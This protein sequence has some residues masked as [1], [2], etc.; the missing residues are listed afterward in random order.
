MWLL[1]AFSGPVLWATSTHLDKY[2]VERYFKGAG[3]AVLMVFTAIV[4]VLALPLIWWW[5]PDVLALP[6]L[7]ITVMTVSGL[8][9]MWAMTVYLQALDGEEASVI[10]PFF[11]LSAVWTLALAYL[12]LHET[13]T[14]SQLAGTSLVFAGG[15][16]L[17]GAGFRNGS[18]IKGT[19]VLRM[20]ACTLILAL[21]GVIFK[22]FAIRDDD[23]WGT[24]FWMF[25]GEALFG[26]AVLLRTT[27][28]RTFLDLLRRS[29]GP[30]VAINAANEL[31][32]LGGGLGVRYAFTLAPIALV[33][34]ITGTTTLFVFLIGI[35]LTRFFPGLGRES[36]DRRD[37]MRKGFAALLVGAGVT[38]MQFAT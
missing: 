38:V 5:H 21:S 17:S 12:V 1:Y 16:L 24:M 33:Q 25:V 10:A 36:L 27:Q 18:R 2:L 8:L 20:L 13:L 35:L 28:R 30:L 23:F 34:T 32:N 6:P 37:L 14:A 15:V 22:F 4:G 26:V 11:Q 3:A 19:L 29:T 7:A 31:I 9:Y